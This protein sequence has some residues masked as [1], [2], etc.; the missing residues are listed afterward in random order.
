M[1][2]TTPPS[3]ILANSPKPDP[4]NVGHVADLDRVARSGLSSREHSPRDRDARERRRRHR[5][6]VAELLED[7]REDRLDRLK[8]RLLR[9]EAHLEIELVE[10]AGRAVGAGVLVA[11]AGRDLEIAVEAATMISCLN[12]CGACG[13]A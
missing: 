3:T 7:A 1:A 6:A 5:L 2:R 8:T 9:H 12:I 13:S 10:L 11:E 4:R